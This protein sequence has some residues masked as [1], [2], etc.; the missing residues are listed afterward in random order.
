MMLD[1]GALS[2]AIAA[3]GPAVRVLV[4]E[5]AGSS[6]REAGAAM[7]V[8]P[9]A[10]EGTIGGGTLEWQAMAEARAMLAGGPAARVARIA[11]GPAL[12]QC[13]GGAVTLVLERVDA[14]WI[15]A[16]VPE[17]PSLR[18]LTGGETPPLALSRIARRW[19]SEGVAPAAPVLAQG[20]IAE[21]VA[22]PAAPLWIWGAGHVG[23]ALV[24]VLAPLPRFALTWVD[25]ARDRFPDHIPPGVAPVWSADPVMLVAQAPR[26]AGHLVL[27]H[28]HVL[29][30]ALCNALLAHGFDHA[31]LIGSATKWARFRA[32]LGALGHDPAQIGRIACPIGNPGLGKHPQ[33]IA[34]GVAAD[35]LRPRM[36][37]A[38]E[39]RA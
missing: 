37:S 22:R 7:L 32:R 21:P 28:S 10:T 31:G 23:R 16:L 27:T 18:R 1:P 4:A 6:P 33:E 14:G 20:W 11:L 36:A 9:A 34:I 17:G 5:T 35:L 3:R 29:D 2:A 13:C 8:W 19:R 24:G 30:L 26:D 38:R 25:M 15:S 39:L 12:G